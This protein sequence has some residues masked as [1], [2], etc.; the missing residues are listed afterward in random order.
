[1]KE[2]SG[3]PSRNQQSQIQEPPCS[4]PATMTP[5]PPHASQ[6][7]TRLARQL[8]IPVPRPRR[9]L[10]EYTNIHL[11][12]RSHGPAAEIPHKNARPHP[13]AA[14]EK[15]K[16]SFP[17]EEN[18]SLWMQPAPRQIPPAK[19]RVQSSSP[20]DTSAESI[21][22]PDAAPTAASQSSTWQCERPHSSF[23]EIYAP[24]V[25]EGLLEMNAQL[26]KW[27]C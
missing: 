6:T 10:N 14:S 5:N 26:T 4:P 1:V 3:P 24:L 20:P 25:P 17:R 8:E 9:S 15:P 23:T 2:P 11:Q 16:N 7:N 19:P 12:D 13:T 22:P 21:H 27:K 18:K